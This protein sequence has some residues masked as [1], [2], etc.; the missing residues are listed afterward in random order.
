MNSEHAQ[1]MSALRMLGNQHG[2]VGLSVCKRTQVCRVSESTLLRERQAWSI[3]KEQ[4]KLYSLQL[5]THTRKYTNG[6]ITQLLQTPEHNAHTQMQENMFYNKAAI[7]MVIIIRM[8]NLLQFRYQDLML[9][10]AEWTLLAS[11]WIL[12]LNSSIEWLGMF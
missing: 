1:L 11:Q 2:H 6:N 3:I 9:H 8:Q 7:P 4:N 12:L 10:W 5:H